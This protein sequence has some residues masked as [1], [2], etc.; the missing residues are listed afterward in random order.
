V[1]GPRPT[2]RLGLIS[3]GCAKNLVD[4]EVMLGHLAG[5][6]WEFVRDPAD[7]DVLVVNTC[8]F[9]GPAREESVTTILE[10]AQ[11]KKTGRL[12]RLIVAG[13]MVQR[14]P[15]ELRREL[16]EVDAF[17]GLDELDRVAAAAAPPA[18]PAAAAGPTRLRVVGQ[19]RCESSE[20]GSRGAPASRYL[21]DHAAPRRLATP[22]W[23][24]YVK[25]AEGCDHT[26]AFCAIPSFRGAFRSRRPESVVREVTDLVASG[27]R[28]ISLIAQDSSAYGRDLDLRDGLAELLDALDGVDGLRW[29]RVHY[30]YPNTVTT[31]LIESMRRARCVVDYVDIPLQHAH[32]DVLARMRRGGSAATHLEL[33]T[34]FRA[35]MPEVALRSTLIVG[36]PGE[37]EA[38]YEALCDFVRRAR[39]EHLG[40]FTYSHEDGTA[41]QRLEDD[42]P[43]PVKVERLER[44]VALKQEI[45]FERNRERIGRRVEVLVEGAHAE[46]E[47]LLVG[48]TRWQAPDVDGQVLINDGSARPGEFVTV[49]LTDVAGYDLVGAIVD[50]A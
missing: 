45:A 3:L 34:R 9:I 30:L 43:E 4:S 23:T 31:R 33:L 35:A 6:G 14:Y 24:A 18:P 29:L 21:Y 10:A 41:A 13:C 39:F 49:E 50:P 11:Y 17:L 15:G 36:F 2:R 27:V 48:R 37:T 38:E 8:S 5:A 44:L 40:I 19:E 47:H 26:C 16:P 46:T 25:I 22:P 32:R 20:P 7:A 28:E 1:S 42:V 12:K